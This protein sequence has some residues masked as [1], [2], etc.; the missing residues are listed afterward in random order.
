MMNTKETYHL[1]SLLVL[2]S[3]LFPFSASS[4]VIAEE[5]LRRDFTG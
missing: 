3:L 2:L 1:S 4:P 5:Y